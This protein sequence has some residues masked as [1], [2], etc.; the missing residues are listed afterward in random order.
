MPFPHT[1]IKLTDE[2]R[3]RISREIRVLWQ[4]NQTRKGKRLQAI[5]MSDA[6]YTIKQI[7]G[8]LGVAYRTVKMWFS[9]YHKVGLEEYIRRI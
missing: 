2:E 7:S 1:F 9:T 8:R 4:A 3:K 6:G 5:W